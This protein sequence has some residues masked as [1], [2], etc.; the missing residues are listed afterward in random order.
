[1]G[2]VAQRAKAG[3][4][5][6]VQVSVDGLDEAEVKLANELKVAVDLLQDGIEDQRFAT[7][8]ARQQVGVG[9]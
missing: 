9:A 5:I 2:L 3:D 4:V 7:A 6:G 8:A 1:V